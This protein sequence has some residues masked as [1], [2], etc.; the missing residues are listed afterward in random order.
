VTAAWLPHREPLRTTLGRTIF[1]AVVAGTVLAVWSARAARPIR[2]PVALVLMLWISFGGHWV[3]LWYLNWLRPRLPSAPTVQRVA[4]L[5]TWFLGGC[6]LGIGMMV[7]ARAL[8]GMRRTQWP[9]W[10]AAG[11]V[12]VGV[13][14][15]VHAMLQARGR[16]SAFNG[17]G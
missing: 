10:W 7:T 17:R 4:R 14:L 1:I 13:E 6:A 12:F 11:L 15:V 9:A 16:P 3:E 8:S 5:G 2:W